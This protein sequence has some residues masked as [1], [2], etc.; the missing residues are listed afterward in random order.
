MEIVIRT[1][2][3]EPVYEQI[4]RQIHQAVNVSFPPFPDLGKVCSWELPICSRSA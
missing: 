1:S 4:V 3:P 2:A